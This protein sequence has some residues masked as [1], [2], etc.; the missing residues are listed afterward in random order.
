MSEGTADK[1]A[2]YKS[3]A[4]AASKKKEKAQEELK[5]LEDEERA[6]ERAV[7]QKEKA[8]AQLRGTKFMKHDDFKQFADGLRAKQAQYKKMQTVIKS[9]RAERTVLMNTEKVLKTK[10]DEIVVRLKAIEIETGTVGIFV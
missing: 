3:Q 5:R 9:V 2:I 7:E 10:A 4:N 1:L 8:Y 6:A